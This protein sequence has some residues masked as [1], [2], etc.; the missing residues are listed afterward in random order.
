LGGAIL[1][2]TPKGPCPQ[3]TFLT[4]GKKK[5]IDIIGMTAFLQLQEFS[6]RNQHV[7]YSTSAELNWKHPFLSL[8]NPLG[9]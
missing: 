7:D 6:L 8:M 1:F 4:A 5:S 3:T 2:R 9:R